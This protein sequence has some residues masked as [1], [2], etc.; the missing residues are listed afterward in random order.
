MLYF[1]T[2]LVAITVLLVFA[3]PAWG[4]D[5]TSMPTTGPEETTVAPTTQG[6]GDNTGI[7]GTGTAAA[8]Q[9]GG[10]VLPGTT[11]KKPLP[12]T[13]GYA[14]LAPAVGLLLVSGVAA[15]LLVVRRR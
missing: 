9:Y 11:S 7:E 4:Q 1:R 5:T 10:K 6:T 3:F 2:M 15:G 14:I 12:N 8:D 13:G